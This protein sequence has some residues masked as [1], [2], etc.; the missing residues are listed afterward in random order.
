MDITKYIQNSTNAWYRQI[1]KQSHSN[2]M[3]VAVIIGILFLTITLTSSSI[4]AGVDAEPTES[5]QDICIGNLPNCFCNNDTAN[6]TAECCSTAKGHTQ[7]EIC[8]I[9]TNTGDYVNCNFVQ[10]KPIDNSKTHGNPPT[11]G[12]LG[13]QEQ[14]PGIMQFNPPNSAKP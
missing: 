5:P 7:C 8:D 11:S 12:T 4:V 1:P 10:G 9:D 6:L 13:S 14:N 2:R 3:A